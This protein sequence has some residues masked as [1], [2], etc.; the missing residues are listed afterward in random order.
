MSG[1]WNKDEARR[2][3]HVEDSATAAEETCHEAAEPAK[4]NPEA[5]GSGH[6]NRQEEM[7]QRPNCY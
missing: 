2:S 6:K 1:C 3:N 7:T 5:E 4:E